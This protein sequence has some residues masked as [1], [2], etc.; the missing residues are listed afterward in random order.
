MSN[1]RESHPPRV[2][3]VVSEFGVLWEWTSYPDEAARQENYRRL[4]TPYILESHAQELA[5]AA[6]ADGIKECIEALRKLQSK[7][8]HRGEWNFSAKP[9]LAPVELSDWLLVNVARVPTQ[10]SDAKQ[11][12]K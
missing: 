9:D 2:W 8:H 10:P 4:A 12:E 3:R 5:S 11:G 7:Y 1:A 6:R